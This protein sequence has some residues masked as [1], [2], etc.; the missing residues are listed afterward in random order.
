MEIRSSGLFKQLQRK[1]ALMVID[2]FST[3]LQHLDILICWATLN[4]N[5]S[6]KW[7]WVKAN[8]HGEGIEFGILKKDT[9]EIV[10]RTRNM[11]GMDPTGL[12]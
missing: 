5:A 12:F 8:Y 4:F 3:L 10:H 1:E 6:Q 9:N 11:K 7:F 2:N